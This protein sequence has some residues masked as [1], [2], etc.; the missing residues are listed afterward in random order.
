MKVTEFAEISKAANEP[1]FYTPEEV[2]KRY[3]FHPA[4]VRKL[5][6]DEEGVIRLGH[7]G[8][9]RRRQYFTLRI[10]AHVIERVLGRMTVTR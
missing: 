5:F 6:I 2:A 7:S 8:T 4:T 3:K 9:R 10:P 1:T